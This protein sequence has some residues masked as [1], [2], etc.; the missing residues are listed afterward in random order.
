MFDLFRSRE[1]SV[2]YLMGGLLTI[3]ALSM[4]ITLVP[5]YGTGGGSRN[6]QVIANVGGDEITI[7]EASSNLQNAMKEARIPP[8]VAEMY[9]PMYVNKMIAERAL[10]YQAKRM[11]LQVTDDEVAA[12]I[13]MM[14]PQLFQNGK[15]VGRDIYAQML[16]QQNLT[17]PQ[18]EENLRK[19][20]LLT[21]LRDL[22]LQG[23]VVTEGEL[24]A[25]YHKE[26]DKVKVAFIAIAQDK[27]K[28]QVTA[29][30]DEMKAYF[31]Q[32]KV[33]F[34]IDEKRSVKVLSLD[35]AT[36]SATLTISDADLRQIYEANK[37]RFRTPE[38]VKVRHILLKTTGKPKEEAAKIKARAEDLLKQI[39]AG[40]DFGE[41]A[42]KYSE[43]TAS[44]VNGGA[45]DWITRG[46]TVANFEKT[47][48]SLKPK[49]ISP[50]IETEYGFHIVQLLEKED[51]RV[52]PF[53]EVKNELA[54]EARKQAV[55]DKL[56]NTVEQA[57]DAVAK[58]PADVDAIAR[59]FGLKEATGDKLARFDPV[60]DVGIN[61]ELTEAV[62]SLAKGGVTP[63]VQAAGNKLAFAVVSEILPSRPAEFSE[64]EGKVRDA[65]IAQK[66][67]RLYQQKIAEATEKMKSANGDLAKLAK[68]LGLDVKNPDAFSRGATVPDL[69]S[70]TYIQ[71]AFDAAPGALLGPL[72]FPD[73][74]AF[75]KV[76]EQQPADMV[77]LIAERD[78]L[79]QR[80]KSEKGRQRQE[81][82]EDSVVTQLTKDGKI[83]INKD[84][85]SRLVANY[86][87]G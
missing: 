16:A 47:A 53:E 38:R 55:I 74:T 59:K 76:V 5:G 40:A 1:K 33:Q 7:L 17:I 9:V 60:P 62:F 34:T 63:V 4:V 82:L 61:Q 13:Q 15:L 81:L 44:A 77:G 24:Q 25:E 75:V 30:P 83:K 10:V 71:Q 72:Q 48:F 21:K 11:G 57:R 32:N 20:M 78:R 87:R 35:E 50:V 3:V 69:G 66:S 45:M 52:K 58:A 36:L 49:E 85:L 42:K 14:V 51:A 80:L 54:T 64:V 39:K 26:H 73:K 46:Q 43:D 23:A 19:Q 67:Q 27:V 79:V 68:E 8:E 70:T 22:V 84:A 41:L 29:T 37:D 2:R 31:T 56:Q 65:V 6:E 12:S 86:K 18:F 28:S